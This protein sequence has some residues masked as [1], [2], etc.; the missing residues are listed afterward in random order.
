M[1]C[2]RE[3]ELSKLSNGLEIKIFELVKEYVDKNT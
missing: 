1:V 3:R 2:E